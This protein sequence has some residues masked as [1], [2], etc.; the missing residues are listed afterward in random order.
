[1]LKKEMETIDRSPLPKRSIDEIKK[2][3]LELL[4]KMTLTEKIGQL[5]E[6]G[7]EGAAISGPSFDASETVKNIREGKVGSLLGLY[8]NDVIYTL[9]KTAVTESRLGIPLLFCND[10]IHG[11]RTLF[12]LNL[13]MSNSWNKELIYKSSKVSAY[14]S[15]H[16]GVNL[17]FSPMLD[18]VRDPRWGR[19]CE[20]NGE[21][22]YLSSELAKAYVKGYEQ[23]DLTSY[24]TVA[25]CAKHFVG[26]GAALAGREYNT[27]D[28]S[29]RHL[30]QTYLKPFEA[31]IEA[32]T[33][34]IMSSFNV[35]EDVPVTANKYLLRDVLRDKLK[36]DGVVISDY[37][38]S[39]EIMNHKVAKNKKEVARKCLEAGLDHEMIYTSYI[40]C[41]EEL[42]SEDDKYLK[43]IDEAC[44]RVLILKYKLGLFDNPYKNIYHDFEDY[45]LKE[46]AINTA[47]EVSLESMVLLKNNNQT[48]PLT[49]EKVLYVGPHFDTQELNGVWGGKCQNKDVI[50]IKE[51]LIKA[52]HSFK[53]VLGSDYETT[54]EELIREAV[55]ASKTVD[56][57]VITVG[58][59][60][61]MSGEAY[62]RSNI[63]LFDSQIRLVKELTKLGKKVVLL[64]FA[65]RPLDLTD[66]CEDVDAILYCYFLGT[67]TG[68]AIEKILYGKACP[69]GKLTMTLPY[70]LGQV[71]IFYNTLNTGRPVEK[72]FNYYTSR[73]ADIPNEPL[74]PF[75]FGLSYANFKYSNLRLDKTNVT[76]DDIITVSVDIYNDSSFKGKEI[77]ELYIEALSFSVSRPNLEL[78]DFTKV[79]FEPFEKKTITFEFNVNKLAYYNIDMLEIVEDGEYKIYV[80]PSS[81][82]LLEEKITYKN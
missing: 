25:S 52:G 51:G 1:M 59:K 62:S 40:D 38:S 33:Q 19:V 8:D 58:E 32:G 56:K 24:D 37:T 18:I 13:A 55:E 73:Y 75:G 43:L 17:T 14:E 64:V 60:H 36:F 68:L 46:E 35:F 29:R 69:S 45:W 20:S 53:Y 9:Q 57:I 2:L 4:N 42:V 11:C 78:K 79:E 70:T 6:A 12:P 28:F 31:A 74:Y 16:S 49:N 30:F 26:Y 54:S 50:S 5:Y 76:K 39:M 44:L 27:V 71:P 67:T 63:K 66:V 41:L 22:A 47:L 65:G 3:S 7:Y 72:D 81:N 80:G 21:D 77:V 10:I 82:N 48:L 15:S 34:M 61:H 23:D